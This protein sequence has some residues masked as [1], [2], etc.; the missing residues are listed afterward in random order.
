M[1]HPLPRPTHAPPFPDS[2]G[3]LSPVQRSFTHGVSASPHPSPR[4]HILAGKV[5]RRRKCLTSGGAQ[6]RRGEGGEHL[7]GSGRC[8]MGRRGQKLP[9]QESFLWLAECRAVQATGYQVR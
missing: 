6:G 7:C 8:R 9:P 5:A 1:Q 2:M 4:P 3:G